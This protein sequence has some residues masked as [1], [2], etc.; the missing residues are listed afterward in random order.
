MGK[1]RVE[2]WNA[3]NNNRLSDTYLLDAQLQLRNIDD[4]PTTGKKLNESGGGGLV[5][6]ADHPAN[7]HL[8]PGNCVRLYSGETLVHTFA[9]AEAETVQV[10]KRQVDKTIT[11]DGE[12]L[13]DEWR[14]SVV[15]PWNPAPDFRPVSADRVWNWTADVLDTSDWSDTVYNL[16]RPAAA[17]QL[18]PEAWPVHDIF[19]AWILSRDSADAHPVG[20]Y[21][22]RI[23]I[24]VEGDRNVA[25]Y[26]AADNDAELWVDSTLVEKSLAQKPSTE[27]F[28]K[29]HRYAFPM[30]SGEH[31]IA[32]KV[33]NW[34]GG[35]INP[36]GFKFVA[37]YVSGETFGEVI[38]TSAADFPWIC[39]D[40]PETLPGFT[41]PEILQMLLTEAQVRG[42][43]FGWSIETHGDFDQIEEYA[44]R[45]GTDYRT[46]LDD[47]MAMYVDARAADE[48]KVLHLWPKGQMDTTPDVTL[49]EASIEQLSNIV[50]GEFT[51]A[52]QG[53]WS[54]GIRWRTHDDSIDELQTV[55]AQ[56][57]EL[58]S[59]NEPRVVDQILDAFLEAHAYPVPSLVGKF[60]D[61]PGKE[62]G[63]DYTIGDTVTSVAGQSARCHGI[64]WTVDRRT[65]DLVP[66]PEWD[67]VASVRRRERER[68][69]QR[70]IAGF[71][72]PATAS[73]LGSSPL[74]FAGTPTVSEVT[75][76]WSDDI[77]EALN[78]VD[79]E[80]P[81]QVKRVERTMRPY[82]ISVEIDEDDL[83]DA[84]GTTEIQLLVNG[85][86]LNALYRIALTT[87]EAYAESWIS[88][89]DPIFPTD[90]VQVKCSVD[91][92]HV[93]GRVTLRLADPV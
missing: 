45:V 15:D 72:G 80:K 81:W 24:T 66:H 27:G 78:E 18:Q 77:T 75:W 9:I 74:I 22:F 47:M 82:H 93:D 46:V 63:V 55:H 58:G 29:T 39:L 71:D 90:T 60:L 64:A 33:A 6:Q 91:G 20:E 88:A 32:I 76:S 8:T 54:D 3:L 38:V 21:L 30:S 51:N 19:N 68:A 13:L 49:D 4:L 42:E 12:D 28:T 92:G 48:G 57:L 84:W 37:A 16:T 34:T 65:G 59:V 5:V 11:V 89:Y 31:T 2:I 56:S 35:E 79:P 83:P 87:T 23:V 70:M 40:L 86:E 17:S 85:V 25:L 53:V 10:A 43:L 26:I 52:V 69:V 36:A 61:L 50:D 7:L 14:H 1:A 67:T 62:A 73:L 44:T 41:A